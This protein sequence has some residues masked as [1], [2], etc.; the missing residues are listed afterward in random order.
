M[1]NKESLFVE[2]KKAVWA[3]L[4]LALG[5]SGFLLTRELFKM[6]ALTTPPSNLYV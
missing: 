5:E 4:D 3:G 6:N 1:E 2:R